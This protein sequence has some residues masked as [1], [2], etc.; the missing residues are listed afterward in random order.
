M[1]CMKCG[2]EVLEGQVF[3]DECL[4]GMEGDPVNINAAV[5]VPTQPPDKHNSHRRPLVNPEEEIK[6]L[7]KVNQNLILWLV[8]LGILVLL[9]LL[10]AYYQQFWD[11]VEE[12]GRNYSVVESGLT[13]TGN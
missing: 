13:G 9:L 1:N 3:C 4:A 12:L 11:V 5:L 8:L 10:L 7:E 2:R 6:R